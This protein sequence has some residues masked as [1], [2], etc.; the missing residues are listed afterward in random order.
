MATEKYTFFNSEGDDRRRYNA[1]D[2][3]TYFDDLFASGVVHKSDS[4]LK[5]SVKEG[6]TLKIADGSAFILGY[7]YELKGGDMSLAVPLASG[8]NRI[9]RV[10]LRLNLAERSMHLFVKP[11]TASPPALTRTGTVWELSL[12]RV[13]AKAGVSVITAADIVDERADAS[14]CGWAR[15]STDPAFI[16]SDTLPELLWRYTL[17]PDTLT[18]QERAAAHGNAQLM[19]M[20]HASK[21][22]TDTNR[23]TESDAKAGTNNAKWLTPYSL[24]NMWQPNFLV[25]SYSGSYPNDKTVD[26]GVE[27]GIVF[28]VRS[29]SDPSEG[30]SGVAGI[31]A[32]GYPHLTNNTSIGPESLSV[33]GTTFTAGFLLNRAGYSF[34]YFIFKK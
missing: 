12:A 31:A 5:T 27:I 9:D 11:G 28:V 4:A 21:A 32:P 19:A 18:A 33:S 24:R 25:G 15:T 10:V 34:N 30:F 13:T 16:P 6:M 14:V 26:V 2:F 8:A 1:F 22:L 29:G 23:A 7:R 3:A 17:F 20:F